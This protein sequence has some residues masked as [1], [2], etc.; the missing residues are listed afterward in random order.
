LRTG[1]KANNLSGP[2]F[3]AIPSI[4]RAKREIRFSGKGFLRRKQGAARTGS[5]PSN[6]DRVFNSHKKAQ[7]AQKYFCDFCAFWRLII[8]GRFVPVA[9]GSNK[10]KK[11]PGSRVNQEA[12]ILMA[13]PTGLEPATSNVTGWR[14]NQLNY[15]SAKISNSKN[16]RS[17][18]WNTEMLEFLNIQFSNSGGHEGTRT[19]NFFLVREAVYH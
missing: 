10:N 3:R 17:L 5:A 14:S 9:S 7:D 19:P 4:I 13:E 18:T 2:A 8:L 12:F 6:N 16:S 11:P 15:D 1:I